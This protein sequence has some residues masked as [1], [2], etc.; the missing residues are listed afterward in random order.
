M[1]SA[2]GSGPQSMIEA[3][4]KSNGLSVKRMEFWR[5]LLNDD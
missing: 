3:D 1:H 5:T 2:Y 4:R